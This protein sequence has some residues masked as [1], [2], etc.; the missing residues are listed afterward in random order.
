[1]AR[2]PAARMAPRRVVESRPRRALD[3][4]DLDRE[5]PAHPGREDVS[6]HHRGVGKGD[7]IAGLRKDSA[8]KDLDV[9]ATG[10]NA[11][12]RSAGVPRFPRMTGTAKLR[13]GMR[14]NRE[15]PRWP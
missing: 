2:A 15:Y 7:E 4:D 12:A 10:R 8:R 6:G 5:R 9:R 11:G 1:L 3:V 13:A 14:P